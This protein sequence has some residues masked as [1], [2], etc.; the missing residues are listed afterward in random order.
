MYVTRH[1][2]HTPR[3]DTTEPPHPRAFPKLQA[4]PPT[5]PAKPEDINT[6]LA[7]VQNAGG[8]G[9]DRPTLQAQTE[10]SD[11]ALD[12]V[13]A[14]FTQG[15]P[16]IFWAGYDTARIISKDFWHEWTVAV[17]NSSIERLSPRRWVDIW[18]NIIP[19]DWDRAVRSVTGQV[20][21]RPGITEWD[22]RERMSTTLDRMEVTDVL[23][24]LVETGVLERK[25][26]NGTLPPVQATGDEGRS[27]TYSATARLWI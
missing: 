13:F 1:Q 9:I 14:S 23:G 19:E 4:W 15:E 12:A 27:V 5:P 8:P 6:V 20:M 11:E 18:G 26:V 22:L 7:A 17:P 24:Y 21:H 16:K 10:L 2:K 25:R 3:P